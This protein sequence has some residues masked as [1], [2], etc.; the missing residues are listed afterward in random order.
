MPE[1][2]EALVTEMGAEM[3]AE[4]AAKLDWLEEH[5]QRLDPA[6]GEP[7]SAKPHQRTLGV[8]PS[9]YRGVPDEV[10]VQPY[11]LYMVQRTEAALAALSG[12]DRVWADDLLARAGLG[13]L[14]EARQARVDRRH[15][16]EVWARP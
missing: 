10:G 14:G 5:Y 15:H 1:T 8:T 3:G 2:L 9:R 4:L 13:C 16:I 6:D 11:L 7:V 12:A